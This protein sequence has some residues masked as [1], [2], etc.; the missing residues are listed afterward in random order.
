MKM[1]VISLVEWQKSGGLM[2][3]SVQHAARKNTA[4]LV[5]ASCINALSA[6]IRCR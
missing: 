4:L 3:F 5:R 2:G 1:P 6:D